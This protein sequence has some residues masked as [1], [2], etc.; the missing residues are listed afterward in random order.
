MLPLGQVMSGTSMPSARTMSRS[1]EKYSATWAPASAASNPKS[2]NCT[3]SFRSAK[4]SYSLS[5]W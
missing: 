1:A 2:W 4:K 3:A 5:S